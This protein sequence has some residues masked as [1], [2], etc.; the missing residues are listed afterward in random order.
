MARRALYWA[1]TR[2]PKATAA[3]E[4]PEKGGAWGIEEEAA[5]GGGSECDEDI[6]GSLSPSLSAR[7]LIPLAALAFCEC[8]EGSRERANALETKGAAV[9]AEKESGN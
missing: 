3:G 8:S 1:R 7:L 2:S 6:A 9:K 5:C 4:G